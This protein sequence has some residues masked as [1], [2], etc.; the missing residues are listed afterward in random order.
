MCNGLFSYMVQRQISCRCRSR[1][2]DCVYILCIDNE[3]H[4]LFKQFQILCVCTLHEIKNCMIIAISVSVEIRC[5]I[6]YRIIL[7]N[8]HSSNPF[9]YDYDRLFSYYSDFEINENIRPIK[10]SII[11]IFLAT[12][13]LT[14][15]MC[16]NGGAIQKYPLD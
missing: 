8:Y 15:T 12:L 3:A 10:Y 5:N 16:C 11:R 14:F 6:D 13:I 7:Y 9:D 4:K 1:V 2:A